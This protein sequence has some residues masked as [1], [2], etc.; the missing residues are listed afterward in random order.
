MIAETDTITLAAGVTLERGRLSDG[1]RGESWPLNGSGAF[2][3]ARAGQ[4]VG[5][6][7]RELA[8]AFS[9]SPERAREDV[10]RFIWHL[11]GLALLN[12]ERGGSRLRR[13]LGWVQLAARLA[14]AGAVP[15]VV[16]RRRPLDTRSTVRG[17][18]SCLLAGANRVGVVAAIATAAAAQLGAVAGPG[19]VLVAL[20]V[21]LCTGL[22]LG[23]HEAAH[24]A[25]LR[26]VPSALVTRGR[27]TYVLHA[28]LA[29]SRRSLVALGGPLTVAGLGLCCVVVGAV[30][31]L[32]VLAVA[33]CPFAAHA[34]ALT[35]VGGDGRVACGL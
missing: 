4:P 22:G 7:V 28:A 26:G 33:G 15:A 10:L 6:T 9:L 1:V 3:L 30:A 18:A 8:T 12:V 2:V 19:G 35:V 11:N 31:A 13:L 23:L 16:T 27:R 32:P 5:A 24:A 21:G 34:L 29:P 20:A 17:L 14:P 25:F